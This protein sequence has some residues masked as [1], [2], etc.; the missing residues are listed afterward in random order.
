MGTPASSSLPGL[1]GFHV[2]R[3]ALLG[4]AQATR[5]AEQARQAL[6]IAYELRSILMGVPWMALSGFRDGPMSY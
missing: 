3:R 1:H 5:L 6:M 4:L 2:P